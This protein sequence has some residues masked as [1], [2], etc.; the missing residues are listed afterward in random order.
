MPEIDDN[1]EV[2]LNMADVRVDTYRASGAGGQHIN[3]TDSAV[4]MTHIPTGTVAQ[5]QSERSQ[6]QNREQCL[7]MLRAKLFALERQ[8][9]EQE[10]NELAGD[11]QAIEWG[12]QIRSYVFHPYNMV[13]D[14]RT[15]AETGNVQAVMDG[16]LE[17]F[18]QAYLR[19]GMQGD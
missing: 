9:Q 19:R 11:Y 8:K 2:D 16:D 7:H 6:I 15:N 17:L 5:C 3:K 13:K 1:V 10:L 14:H 18:I 12:S 4:R